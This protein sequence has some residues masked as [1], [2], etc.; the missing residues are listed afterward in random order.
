[1]ETKSD[2]TEKVEASPQETESTPKLSSEGF[3]QADLAGMLEATINMLKANG[4]TVGA[5][6]AKGVADDKI[7]NGMWLFFPNWEITPEGVKAN[8]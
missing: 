2:H 7:M 6:N 1:M 4:I 3:T 8:G 5:A